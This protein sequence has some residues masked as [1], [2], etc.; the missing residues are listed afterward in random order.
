MKTEQNKK[1]KV[2]LDELRLPVEE[3]DETMRRLFEAHRKQAVVVDEANA[4]E[5]PVKKRRKETKKK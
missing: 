3:F 2:D 1:G 4:A 5:K